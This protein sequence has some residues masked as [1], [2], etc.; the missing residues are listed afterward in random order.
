LATEGNLSSSPE[1]AEEVLLIG[2]YA[3]EG[4]SGLRLRH[5]KEER[6]E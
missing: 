6:G 1:S 5:E 3:Y 4:Y 2:D